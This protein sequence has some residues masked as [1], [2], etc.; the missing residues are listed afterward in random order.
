MKATFPHLRGG[1]AKVAIVI[2][3]VMMVSV[4]VVSGY[5]NKNIDMTEYVREQSCYCHGTEVASNVTIII[6]VLER[7]SYSPGNRSIDVMVGI[8]GEPENLT[9][10][11]LYLNTSETDDNVRWRNSYTNDTGIVPIPEDLIKVNGTSLWSVG[12]ITDKW[13]NVSF[14]PGNV[15]QTIVV[16]VAGMRA[17]DNQNVSG[18]FW[19]VGSQAV[20][21]R[22]QR[23]ATLNVTVTNEQPISVS[24]VLVDF[25]VDDEYIGND[26]IQHIPENGKENASVEW[27]ITYEK[28][29]K[30]DMRAVIDPNGMITVL[31]RDNLEIEVE[32][33]LGEQPE[34][35]DSAIYYG[36]GAV[37]VGV[38]LIFLVFWYWR[39]RQYQF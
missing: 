35:L 34:D 38:I 33:W 4:P 6:E 28:D 14:V 23:L 20:E 11:G 37:L 1:T 39:R 24:E 9:G 22:E 12:P 2:L 15:D 30:H 10:F 16:S 18:D 7:V 8:L 31:D 3:M 5:L 17:N 19:N 36:L 32:I 25:Y 27:D 13:F 21:V 26:T 29:G